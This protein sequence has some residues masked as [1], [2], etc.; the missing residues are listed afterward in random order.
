MPRLARSVIGGITAL[1]VALFAT[2]TAGAATVSFGL[3]GGEQ[4]FVVP[5]GVTTVH[6]NVI[7]KKCK[8]KKR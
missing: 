6:V 1:T 8:K 2:A 4:T 7:K 5:A 3:T